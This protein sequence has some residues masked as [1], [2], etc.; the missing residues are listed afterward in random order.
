[1]IS[2]YLGKIL[3]EISGEDANNL[4]S[5]IKVE[6][7]LEE[8]ALAAAA[9]TDDTVKPEINENY[10]KNDNGNNDLDDKD[11]IMTTRDFIYLYLISRF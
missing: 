7:D 5:I 10:D 1:M 6:T 3:K 2:I 11:F 4:S 8:F 9:V